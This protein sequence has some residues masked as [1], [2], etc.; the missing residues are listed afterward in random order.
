MKITAL[1]AGLLLPCL[2]SAA[3]TGPRL[4]GRTGFS[5]NGKWRVIV[6][7]YDNGYLDYRSQPYDAA[8]TPRG[9][10]FLDH[11]P[12]NKSEL[13]EYDFDSSPTL[14]VPGDWNSQDDKL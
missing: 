10:Y 4:E 8:E 11:K 7:P 14:M 9:G 1:A 3:P 12:A 6:D 13:V 5:L 2:A